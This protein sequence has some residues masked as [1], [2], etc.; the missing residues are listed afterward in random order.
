MTKVLSKVS[1]IAPPFQK[2]C[3]NCHVA[4]VT[5][6]PTGSVYCNIRRSQLTV[7][8]LVFFCSSIATNDEL[9]LLTIKGKWLEANVHMIESEF[10][11]LFHPK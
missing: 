7:Q 5:I 6:S 9:V 4:N 8:K 11:D 1:P 2:V 3:G 10:L